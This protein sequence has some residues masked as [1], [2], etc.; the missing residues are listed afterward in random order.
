MDHFDQFWLQT[1]TAFRR[2]RT[3]RRARNL[4]LGALLALGRRTVS[5]LLLATG[6]QFADWSAAYRLFE[7]ERFDPAALLAP[8]RRAA[9]A[10]LP[11]Q[12]PLVALMDDTLLRKRGRK[13][14]GV[15]WRRDPLGPHFCNNFI[16]AQ[17][18]LQ[19]SAA[20]PEAPGAARARAVPIDLV[21]CPSPKK[22]RRNAP[23]TEWEQYRRAGQQTKLS[24]RGVERI[25]ALRQGLDRD[26]QVARG[27]IV[28][29]D[30]G[31]TNTAVLRA[32]PARTTLIGRVR[33]DAKLYD[34]APP[35]ST[36]Q[37]GRKRLYGAPLPTPEALRQDE[38]IAWQK[39]QAFAA[40][41]LFDFEVKQLGPVRWRGAGGRDLQ[42]VVIRP[43]AYR[44]SQGTRLLYREPAYLLCTDP[45]LPLAQLVQSYVW[46]WEIELN[47]R[48]QKTLLGTGEAQ[49]RTATAAERVPQLIA[50]AYAYLHLALARWAG[51]ASGPAPLPRPH[52]QQPRAHERCSTQQGLSLLRAQVWGRALGVENFSDFARTQQ[53][54]TK[55]QIFIPNPASAVFYASD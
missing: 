22:P 18:F 33:K 1:R 17:R 48:D 45:A 42:L 7:K 9:V 46:R 25:A 37:R 2:E 13:I 14:A 6:Q 40:G 19:I 11:P 5:G 24:V 50:A 12:A 4:A 29:V 38:S 52:W 20:L 54:Q 41:R 30:G 27:L 51:D 43:L 47:F 32:L 49:V 34:C 16:W 28:A 26:G 44:K 36:T 15:S 53:M 3:W 31:Y 23:Q 55:S 35:A 21:H 8:A 39:V 10:G